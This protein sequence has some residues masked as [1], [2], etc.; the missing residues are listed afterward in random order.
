MALSLVQDS[1]M[2]TSK[3]YCKIP[4]SGHYLCHE[5]YTWAA[6]LDGSS[7]YDA[8]A[9]LPFPKERQ[10]KSLQGTRGS[11]YLETRLFLMMTHNKT[12]PLPKG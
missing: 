9:F 3:P 1:Q 10:E 7:H 8:Y 5:W 2:L 11:L 12:F 4:A 6:S